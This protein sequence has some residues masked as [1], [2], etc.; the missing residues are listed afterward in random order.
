MGDL[1][2]GM[3]VLQAWP[4]RGFW[5]GTVRGKPGT[6]A[7]MTQS[8]AQTSQPHSLSEL[9]NAFT[10][11]SEAHAFA[12]NLFVVTAL[13]LIGVALLTAWRPVLFPAVAALAVLSLADWVLVQDMGFFGGLGTDPNSMIPITLVVIGGYLALTRVPV[14]VAEPAAD[15]GTPLA[16]AGAA[17]AAGGAAGRGQRVGR[18]AGTTPPGR[19]AAVGGGHQHRRGGLGR[20]PGGHFPGCCPDGSSTGQSQRGAD[21]GPVAHR[22]CRADEL[23]G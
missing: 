13:G 3:A 7:A 14:P 2:A 10:T 12:V 4:G 6:L 19:P 17:G 11:F 1:F 8:M 15:P 16:T 22:I 18:V 20:R 23:R 21:P 9:I 5:Q